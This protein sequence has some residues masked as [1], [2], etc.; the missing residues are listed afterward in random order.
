M[1][2]IKILSGIIIVLLLLVGLNWTS[3]Q[4]LIHV[5]TL[6]D[7]GK[8][9]QNFSH[10]DDLLFSSA[11]P[12]S[13]EE[14]IWEINLSA[15][16]A[17]FTDRGKVRDTIEMLEELQTT[18]LVV[19]KDGS[20][21]FEEYYKGTDED[22]L[23]ISWSM[24]KSFVSALMGVALE[25]G[26]IESIDD[27]V[28]RYAPML[29]G[30]AYDGVPLRHVLNMAS[31]IQFDENYLDPGSDINKMGT[32]LA[33]GGSLDEFAA[34]QVD[35]ARPSG[36]AWQYCSID[37]HV[38]S[39]VLRS[40]TG[41]TLQEYFVENLWSR[42]G[43]SADAKYTTDGDGN[44]FA[45]G[46]LNMRTRDYALFG[47]LI[48]NHGRRGEEQII[49]AD[50]VAISTSQTAPSAAEGAGVSTE[51]GRAFGYGYQW[52]MP[53]NSDGEFYA[54]GVYGQ[55]IYINPK[56][57][58]VIA[59]NAAHREFMS[60][61]EKGESYMAQNITLFRGISEHYSVWERAPVE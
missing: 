25:R 31:G 37:T 10:M 49:P 59:K 9:V 11:L 33:L 13:G 53:P 20:I 35:I 36:T 58:I 55:Y 7:E 60:A 50:W 1:K 4:R 45:L 48:R 8:I 6:F 22:D 16:P 2:A 38:V 40:A 17:T 47:E 43:A 21:V 24:S 52:W 5:K 26:E 46:G 12:R 29:K 41:K 34:E 15:L 56:A 54:V 19:V 28:T 27:P 32:V 3:I 42:I 57:G 23:R 61:D 44:A 18:A 30:S 51:D 14:D 39:M